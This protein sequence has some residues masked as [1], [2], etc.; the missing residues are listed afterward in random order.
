MS[1]KDYKTNVKLCG[2]AG[3]CTVAG[4]KG[5]HMAST[6]Y[7]LGEETLLEMRLSIYRCRCIST[8]LDP[9][10]LATVPF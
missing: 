5:M 7:Q 4:G 2:R 10:Q 9:L 1:S 6:D 3:A 8:L